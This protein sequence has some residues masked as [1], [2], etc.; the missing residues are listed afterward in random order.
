MQEFTLMKKRLFIAPFNIL[1]ILLGI[2]A[3]CSD[4]KDTILEGNGL[5]E[6]SWST[7][8]TYS[9]SEGQTLKFTFNARS[10]WTANS[11]STTFL[12][13]S[14]NSGNSGEN[15]LE[16]TANKSSQQQGTVTIKVNGYS[17]ETYINLKLSSNTEHE[18][19]E[20]NYA[21]D[22]YLKKMYL[23]NDDYKKLTPDFTLSY[24]KFLE[25]T[26]MS[27]TTNTLDKKVYINNSGQSYYAL[28]SFIQKLD[29]DLQPT[30]SSNTIEKKVLQYN[31]GFID[32]LP[33]AYRGTSNSTYIFLAVQGVHPG[34]SAHQAGIK[35]G[36][37]ITQ[38]NGQRL[39]E[40]NWFDYYYNL[41]IP[42]SSI[43]LEVKDYEGKTYNINSGPI[44]PNPVILSQ[45]KQIGLHKIGY[46]A[47]SAFEAGFD[48]EL[49]D[50][51][52]NFH[53]QSIT[54]L[55]LDLRYNGGGHV[56]SANLMASCIAGE[57]CAG[58]TFASYRYNS[59]RMEVLGNQRPTEQFA[60]S[61]YANLN[62]T[63]LAAGAL[64]LPTVYCLVSNNTASSSELV[65]NSLKGI[66]ID[67]KLIG[68]TTHGKNVGME[69]ITI[70]TAAAK[71]EL[72]PITFQSYNAKGN[73]DYAN[74][75]QPEYIID[76][77]APNGNNMFEGYGDFGTSE[78]PLYAIA[79]SLITGTNLIKST[80]RSINK[81]V[82]K[83]LKKP[84]VKHIGMIK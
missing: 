65:I 1:I 22:E 69:G 62:N 13:L 28:F 63:S 53:N 19:N 83:P 39:T 56:I 76:E 71:Y 11:N 43:S 31:F 58:K 68:M 23:W 52:K 37:K 64:N 25:N 3:S 21:V 75:F 44:Y 5:K 36:T 48:Q 18:D 12:T 80:T 84:E 10:S 55:I 47:Y 16:I 78:D 6:K 81:V 66:G 61:K 74:G 67:V 7:D 79:E 38:I 59:S 41:R 50:T 30:R 73:G 54:D 9:I 34:S 70:N 77:D 33:V 72:Y 17:V 20:V 45:V 15:T 27:M 51:F 60:Y 14:A 82:G 42:T 40:N 49:F 35:R 32:M 8:K 29:P 26:L 2:I 57:A 4:D 24:D 46:L